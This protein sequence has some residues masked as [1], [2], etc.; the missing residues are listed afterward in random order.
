MKKFALIMTVVIAALL[1]TACNKSYEG[2]YKADLTVLHTKAYS[3][4]AINADGTA[5]IK[6]SDSEK[7]L[8][9]TWKPYVDKKG[10]EHP[11]C[12]RIDYNDKEKVPYI[13]DF[14]TKKIYYG[15]ITFIEKTGRPFKKID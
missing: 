15:H 2:V 5:K 10:V 1:C 3:T 6:L 14:R 8:K 12:I 4:I 9:G 11:K 7:T 13:M